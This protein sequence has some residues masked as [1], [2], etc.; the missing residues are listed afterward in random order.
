MREFESRF[1][2]VE[3]RKTYGAQFCRRN[4]KANE[5]VEEYAAELKCLY[6]KAH[7]NRDVETRQEDLLR[8]FLDGLHDDGARFHVEFVK[9]PKNIDEAAFQVVDFLETRKRP[10]GQDGYHDYKSKRPTRVVKC[11]ESSESRDKTDTTDEEEKVCQIRKTM[12]KGKQKK[13]IYNNQE[14]QEVDCP[15]LRRKLLN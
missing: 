14:T 13:P 5:T 6:D 8:K 12:V 3:T 11:T 15:N 9:E 1:R 2:I 7:A 4:Q 10:P